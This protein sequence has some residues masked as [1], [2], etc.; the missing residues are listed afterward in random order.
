MKA[1]RWI[2]V[3]ALFFGFTVLVLYHGWN[4]SKANDKIRNYLITTLRPA[5]G[6]DFNIKGLDMSLGAI[7]LKNVELYSR[8]KYYHLKI[9]D[10]R[11][12]FNFFN[13]IKS[14]FRPKRIPQDVIFVK[15][16]LTIHSVDNNEKS[17]TS[18]DSS[19]LEFNA[20]QYLKKIEN[21]R[22]IKRITISKGAVS[23]VDSTNKKLLLSN[24]INGWLSTHDI[25][26]TSIR[27]VGKIFNSKSFNLSLAGFM[28]L[29]TGR[30][31]HLNVKLKNYH[32]N[33]KDA[34]FLPEYYD[35][36]QGIVDGTLSLTERRKPKRGF[37]INGRI[38]ISDGSIR[39]LNKKLY[40]EKINIDAEIEDWNCI[41]KKANAVFNGAP[42]VVGGRINNIL[43]PRMELK[44]KSD[45]LATESFVQYISTHSDFN[46]RGTMSLEFDVTNTFENPKISG[47]MKCN[48]LVFNKKIFRQLNAHVSYQDSLLKIPEFSTRLDDMKLRSSC[49]ISFSKNH[50]SVEYALEGEGALFKKFIKVP[51]KALRD[52][53][54]SFNINGGGNFESIDGKIYL[55]VNHFNQPDTSFRFVGNL[56]YQG[57]QLLVMMKSLTHRFNGKLVFD[58]TKP[59]YSASYNLIGF[60]NLIHDFE[61]YRKFKRFF[62]FRESTIRINSFKKTHRVSGKLAW[63]TGGDIER[64]ASINLL[65]NAGGKKQKVE[66]TALVYCGEKYFNCRLRLTKAMDFLEI[67]QFDIDNLMTSEGFI[68]LDSSNEIRGNV[69]FP[70]SPMADFT[71]FFFLDT[72]AIDKGKIFGGAAISGTVQNPEIT[73]KLEFEDL[74]FNQIGTYEGVFDF[75]FRNKKFVLKDLLIKRNNQVIIESNGYY[76]IANDVLDFKW[77][78]NNLEL[79]STLIALFNKSGILSGIGS[80]KLNLYGSGRSPCLSGSFQI[81]Q[82]KLFRFYFDKMVLKFG[83]VKPF[84][85]VTDTG[86]VDSL[87]VIPGL[88]I[89]QFLMTRNGEFQLAGKG[90]LPFSNADT[91]KVE[92]AGKGNFLAILPELTSFFK[93]TRSDGTWSLKLT[94]TPNHIEFLDGHIRLKNGYL[95]LGNVAPAIKDISV[96]VKLEQDGFLKVNHISGKIRRKPFTFS[97]ERSIEGLKND[98]LIPFQISGLGLNLGIFTLETSNKGIPLHIPGLMEKGEY[99]NMV[100]LG[101]YPDEKFYFAG[102]FNQPDIR[103]KIKLQNINFT[104]PFIS[105]K[106]KTSGKNPV[107]EV[108]R[109][110][111]WNL[112][113]ITGKNVHY[114]RQIP[115]GLDNVYVDL[116]LDAGVGALDFSGVIRDNTFG[117]TGKL[118]SSRGN[119]EYLNLNFQV[120]KAGAEFDMERS[121]TSDVEFDKSSLLPIIYGEARTTVIDSTGFPYYIYLTLLTKDRETGQVQKRGRLGEVVFQLSSENSRLGDTEGEILAS[122]GYSP[123]DIK[124][125]ATDIIGISADNL[126]F[127]PLFRPIERQLEQTLGLDMVRF[128]SRF[129]RNLIEMNVSDERNFM[130]DSK[131]FLLRSTKVLIGKYLADQLFLTYSGQLEAG[132]DYRYQHE[133]FGVSHRFG[134][135]YRINP[136][137]LL[138]MEY[139]YNSLLIWRRE[140]KKILLRHSFPF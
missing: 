104:F 16:H 107:V 97:N 95:R 24:D 1:R 12:G 20:D 60:H 52:S 11:F 137:L 124:E 100:F 87:T 63:H 116:I 8:E 83:S 91:L 138:Q 31:D 131:L 49:E 122:L 33:K 85:N 9:E 112:T 7:H 120:T 28:N 130:I 47:S 92:L 89:S 98:K 123:S 17:S 126:V 5:L 40:L 39:I 90:F 44:L 69:K 38:T 66:G 133:G 118:E 111:N 57:R 127:R 128:S 132:M 134:L 42:V 139:D 129:T 3:I 140:D 51:F 82:G 64:T 121:G 2:L 18:L 73:G 10:I 94:G 99:G 54:I 96:S 101:K 30:L 32:W 36:Q 70:D 125:V 27:L 86:V 93:E 108:L 71:R 61:E 135:E 50:P 62:S 79:N 114:Q 4:L 15:P 105:K 53:K 29:K 21:F 6:E 77:D 13:L 43:N 74:I 37:N 59:D 67:D 119:V 72:K 102:P 110:I 103:G 78:G 26:H 117:V 55:F 58:F 109:S 41:I 136:S 106:K 45:S 81:Q 88:N 84:V 19:I 65:I 56:N 113:T 34:F 25:N 14:G 23:Y 35:I 68:S 75:G 46:L 48:R 80:G 115:S 22:F 76:D